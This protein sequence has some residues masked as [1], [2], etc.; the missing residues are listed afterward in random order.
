MKEIIAPVKGMSADD[1]ETFYSS[2]C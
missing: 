1:E 2:G